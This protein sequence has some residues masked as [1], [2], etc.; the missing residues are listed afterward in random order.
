[1]NNSIISAKLLKNQMKSIRGIETE[2]RLDYLRRISKNGKLR[3]SRDST[4]K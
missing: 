3:I 4:Q 2:R 1:M